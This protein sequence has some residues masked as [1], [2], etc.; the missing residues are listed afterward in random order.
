MVEIFVMDIEENI[1]DDL[2]H[3]LFNVI[4]EERKKK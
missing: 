2:Y 4:S 3:D 1:S